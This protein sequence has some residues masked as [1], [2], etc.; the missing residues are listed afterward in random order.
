MAVSVGPLARVVIYFAGLTD[1][2]LLELRRRARELG[3]RVTYAPYRS[4]LAYPF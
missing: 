2:S 4:P 3:A 1:T